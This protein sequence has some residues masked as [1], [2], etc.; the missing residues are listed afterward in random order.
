MSRAQAW[1][2]TMEIL[3]CPI[4]RI[5]LLALLA[6][7]NGEAE[8]IRLVPAQLQEL[9]EDITMLYQPPSG[10]HSGFSVR[11]YCLSL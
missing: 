1:A 8:P 3:V 7:S 4:T 5:P 2:K 10:L 6:E 11:L 9:P